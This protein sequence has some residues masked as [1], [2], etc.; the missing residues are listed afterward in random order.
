MPEDADFT[1][2]LHG[3]FRA[4]NRLA[5]RK[6]LM[7]PCQNLVTFQPFVIEADKIL[8]NVQQPFF[9]ENPFEESREIGKR[10]RFLVAVLR[11]PFHKA[12]VA[13]R[14]RARLRNKLV[15]HHANAV[16]NEQTRDFL[17]VIT[18]LQVG[19]ACISLFAA[20]RL[21]LKQANRQPVQ[22]QQNIGPL[23]GPLDNCPLVRKNEGIV[24]DIL[25]INQINNVGL[26]FAI[27]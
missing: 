16:V 6:I 1:V 25:V 12:V 18:N 24:L 21:E 14:N 7:V 27:L 3:L 13:A 11:L 4:D 9:L 19:F 17:H 10:S 22:K 26:C 23:V 8:D 20:R 5:D 15:R 2:A